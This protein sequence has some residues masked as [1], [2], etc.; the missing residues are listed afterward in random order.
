MWRLTVWRGEVP[1][2]AAVVL[3]A[4]VRLPVEALVPDDPERPPDAK[5]LGLVPLD[6]LLHERKLRALGVPEDVRRSG[7]LHVDPPLP[8]ARPARPVEYDEAW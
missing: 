1:P 7:H 4:V 6:L 8:A 3:E 2:L 5:V